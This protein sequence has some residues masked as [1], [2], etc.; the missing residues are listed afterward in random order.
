MNRFFLAAFLTLPA[1]PG[2]GGAEHPPRA[3]ANPSRSVTLAPT[4]M[5]CACH[6]L[7]VQIGVDVLRRGGNAVDA[8]VAVNAALG[9]LEPM[10]C[11]IGGDLF[12]IVWDARTGKIHGL[13]A[14]GRAPALATR[15]YFVSRGMSEIPVYGPL[16]WSVPGCVNGWNAL[17]A[18]FGTRPLGELLEPSIG[19]AEKGAPVPEVVAGYWKAAQRRLMEDPGSAK[20]FLPGGR[21]PKAGEL[22]R[23]PSI[24]SSYRLLARDGASAFYRGEI[25]RKLDAFARENGGLLRLADLEN[26][27]PTWVD[28]VSATY[29]GVELHE[30]PPN[31][32]GLAALQILNMLEP[33]DIGR[34]G[35]GSEEYWHL[36][37]EAKKLAFADRSRFY[38]DMDFSRVPLGVL[39]SKEYAKARAALIRTD[40]VL[41][42][43]EP[44]DPKLGRS[45]TTYLCVVD[46]DRNCVSL[47]QSNYNG[48]GSG[49]VHPELGFGMQNRGTLFSLDEKHPNRLEPGKRPFHTIIP[50]LALRRGK[51]WLVFGVMGGDMQPQG[52]AQVLVNLLDFGMDLQ[53]AGEAPRV[54]HTGSATPTGNPAKG[55][56]TVL[57]EEGMPQA[58]IEGLRK[59]GHSVQMVR[60][61]GGGYQAILIDPE[62]SVL[63]GASEHRKDGMAAGY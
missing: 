43:V 34:M 23:N 11:G 57:V 22:F 20:V 16:S 2:A 32:Q 28:T 1:L 10:S 59:I 62:T 5:V 52:H 54:E 46:K 8:A 9:V 55:Q 25:A 27:Q 3:T 6:P 47:I 41:G 45:D 42:E 40:R 26:D 61:N 53:E 37:I 39:A 15:A 17:L 35:F 30:L 14:S 29:R 33:F 58:V 49:K 13:N 19:Y 36:F 44:G 7:A 24:A 31:G 60:V 56:G 4:A 48:F 63:H 21:S 38:A 18:R 50:A 12:A 51:P